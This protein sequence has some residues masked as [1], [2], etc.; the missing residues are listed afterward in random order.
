[1]H[2]ALPA[3][4][5]LCLLLATC[6]QAA[7]KRDAQVLWD[8]I[9]SFGAA[10]SDNTM[11]ARVRRSAAVG[12]VTKDSIFLHPLNERRSTVTYPTVSAEV[13]AGARVFFLGYAG[14]SDG[15]AWDET[16][17]IPDGVRFW[18][19]AGGKD[20]AAET[21]AANVWKPLVAEFP[22]ANA[23]GGTFTTDLVLA[24]DPGAAK[25]TN[26]DWALIGEPVVVALDGRP[27]SEDAAVSGAGG[28]VVAALSAG[29]GRLIVEG[30]DASGEA[31]PGAIARAEFPEGSSH[32]FV[33]FD[34]AGYSSCVAWRWKTEGL[35]V[36]AAW[37]GTWAP[38]LQLTQLDFAAAVSFAG[39][40][41]RPRVAVKNVGAGTL[42]ASDGAYVTCMGARK[43]LPRL[44]PGELAIVDFELPASQQAPEPVQAGLFFGDRSLGSISVSGIYLWPPLPKLP[45][46]RPGKARAER[47]SADYLLLENANS[48]WVVNLHQPGLGALV[49]VWSNGAWEAAGTMSPWVQVALATGWG[50][51]GFEDLDT[52][53]EAGLA[54]IRGVARLNTGLR[55]GVVAELSDF[56]RSLRFDVELEAEQPVQLRAFRGPALNAGDRG[57]GAA[58]G[59]AI[60]PGLEYLEGDEASSSTR[61]LAPPLNERWTPHKFKITVPMM[62]V[63]TRP[64][65]P[66]LGIAWSPSQTWDGAQIAPAAS[67]ASPDFLTL[68]RSHLM[69]L[70]LPSVPDGIPES[71]RLGAAPID[72]APGQTWRLTGHII[73]AQ[74]RGDATE[75]LRWF[76]DI[77]GYPQ[78]EAPPRSYEDE[79]ALCRHGFMH[80]VWEEE[81]QTSKHIVEKSGTNAP[82][83][84]TLMLMDA[85]TVASGEARSQLLDRVNLIGEK[86]LREQGTAG[87]TSSACCHIMGWEFPYHWGY[88]PGALEGMRASAYGALNNQ[89]ADG[90]WGF[91][92]GEGRETLGARGTR[93]MGICGQNAYRM[94]K[95]AAISG[96]PAVLEALGRAL[97]AMRQFKVPRGAQ[98]WEC[99]ILEPDVLASAY[100]VRAYVW[101]YMATGDRQWL[102]DADFWARTGL[103]FQYT[104]DDGRHPGMRY[105]SIPVFGSTFFHHSWIGLP[106]Q[107]CGLVYAYS[108]Q[109]LMRFAPDS[110]W[111]KQVEGITVSGM[112]QQWPMDNPELAGTYPDSFGQWFTHRN[113]AYINPEDIQVNLMALKGSDPGLRSALV[114]MGGPV[115]VCA[116]GD[117]AAQASEGRLSVQAKY[118]P[119]EI[120][121][122]S[123]GPVEPTQAFAATSGETQLTRQPGLKPGTIGWDHNR[124]LN[125]LCLGLRCGED[126]V[127]RATLSGLGRTIPAATP[128]ARAWEFAGGPEGWE[129]DHN[130]LVAPSDGALKITV[131][132]ADPYAVSGP[133]GIDARAN[134]KLSARV[135]LSA[136]RALGLFWRSSVS[137][138]WGPDK[139][140]QVTVPGD[141]AWHEVTWDLSEHALWD[142]KVLQIRLDV[143]PADVPPGTTLEVDWIRPH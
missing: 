104:W 17:R 118:V 143:E 10:T 3:T 25:N 1:M 18:V 128:E 125:V 53:N 93:T 85:R 103:P 69:Q 36:T 57:T 138:G 112:H 81:T 62:M 82:G 98:G 22:R 107:W 45:P 38:E 132:G 72:L 119:G 58:K 94:A 88:L 122:L 141:G 92:P 59:I 33:R 96:D 126:G 135:R 65:G 131:T 129:G 31:V 137:P 46:A 47:L 86:T 15:F 101:A 80:T 30:L 105:A 32:A 27:L 61:D 44:A 41:L 24:T 121:Y 79:I 78:A 117:V 115:H 97:V 9:A 14:I 26:Y 60:F 4:S 102:Q 49:Y 142:G 127:A 19:T 2:W 23:A 51:P 48:R 120:V 7:E 35:K 116:P 50:S 83:F 95:Y 11:E 136:G 75:A 52:D 111:R 40:A 68:H 5:V 89:E 66:V 63:E 139:E 100:A 70:M 77:I 71:G 124:N 110:L 42:L 43:E 90:L 21:V 108:L 74:P 106:V 84:A 54:R 55:C 20:V 28:V 37:G 64:A 16:G 29:G 34:F 134:K 87:L 67:F 12:K 99:P 76:D 56:D 114:D 130:C 113:G 39:E 8:G 140:M 73:A 91:Y 109:E 6:G 123:V 133:A 13:A